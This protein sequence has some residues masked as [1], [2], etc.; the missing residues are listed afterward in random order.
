VD[1]AGRGGGQHAGAGGQGQPDRQRPHGGRGPPGVAQDVVAGEPGGQPG[2]AR[3]RQADHPPKQRGE[4]RPEGHQANKQCK[5]AQACHE[6]APG[7]RGQP[8]RDSGGA[9]G[10]HG[11]PDHGL[12]PP[13]RPRGGRGGRADRLQRRDLAGAPGRGQRGGHGGQRADPEPYQHGPGR[14]HQP[15]WRECVAQ[16]AQQRPEAD[17]RAR[18]GDDPAGGGDQPDHG[19]LAQDRAEN[20]AA[21]RAQQP[22]QR[23]LA[24]AAG[25]QHRERVPDDEPAHQQ[26]HRR[27]HQQDRAEPVD[28]A[29]HL[30]GLPRGQIGRG[31]RLQPPWG[32]HPR[33]PVAQHIGPHPGDTAQ[34]HLVDGVAA[35]EQPLRCGGLQHRDR[36][37][38]EAVQLR[39]GAVAAG[40]SGHADHPEAV[41]ST[42]CAHDPQ[43]V[44]Q[45]PAPR[46]GG[47]RVQHHLTTADGP[48]TLPQRVAAG[49]RRV[50]RPAHHQVDRAPVADR[51]A[52]A[53]DHLQLLADHHPGRGPHTRHRPDRGGQVR[54]DRLRR[55][56]L[57]VVG[58]ADH[59]VHASVRAGGEGA[60]R[61]A[62]GVGEHQRARYQ[63]HPDHQRDRGQHQPRPILQQ[64]LQRDLQ[65]RSSFTGAA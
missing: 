47:G 22:Q 24:G 1:R 56:S 46:D 39:G 50:I 11:K 52:V 17:R 38:V 60:H 15:A 6:R 54:A 19:R 31:H 23:D 37:G 18:A 49:Q 28:I 57:G 65:H 53:A 9:G 43:R 14:Q 29:L 61:P 59:H 40:E 2:Q 41:H 35:A 44:T 8:G 21:G 62:D 7:E 55:A 36:R 45:P 30:V 3:H 26:R 48:A 20:L 27:E 34:V 16:A 64:P 5:R 42:V 10:G 51:L 63:R 25:H 4:H 13:G 33:D 58:V 32:Q 12:Q